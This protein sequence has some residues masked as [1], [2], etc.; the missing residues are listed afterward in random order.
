MAKLSAGLLMYRISKGWLEV[1]LVHPGGPYFK[2]KDAGWWT[3]PK[4]LVE[5]GEDPLKAAQREFME[6]TGITS[7]P[8]F[9]PLGAVKQKGGKIVEAWAFVGA[10]EENEGFQS[11]TFEMEWPP[12]TG[13]KQSF[14]E[15]DQARWFTIDHAQ[16]R[17]NQAQ[18]PLILNLQKKIGLQ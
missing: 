6:E 8:P 16:K 15:V 10:W 18:I 7:E 13:K 9:L 4:G 11:N 1:F 17:I 5:D 14:P 12:K 3:I 2:N